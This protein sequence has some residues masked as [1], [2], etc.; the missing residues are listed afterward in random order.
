MKRTDAA[1]MTVAKDELAGRIEPF[2]FDL[3]TLEEYEI[4]RVPAASLLTWNRLDLALK[5]LYLD[6]KDKNPELAREIYQQ[7]IRSQTL[8]TFVEHGNTSK[9][10]FDKYVSAFNE[11]AQSVR[12]EGFDNSK[13][14]VPLSGT[15]AIFNGAHRVA[16]AIHAG[17]EVT[18]ALTELPI[19]VCDYRFY[20]RSGVPQK[21]IEM[22]VQKYV[23]HAPGVFIAFLW[24][25]GIG[26]L[27]LSVEKF[28]NIVY[29]KTIR[30][31]L[32]GGRNLLLELYKH[33]DWIGSRKNGYSGINQKLIEC[34]PNESEVTTVVFQAHTLDEVREIKD[35]IRQIHG[36]GFSS[37]HITDTREE[38][39]RVSRLL[40]NEHGL[41]F[42]NYAIPDKFHPDREIQEFKQFIETGGNKAADV[43][44]DGSFLL[45][46][47]GIRESLDVDFLSQLNIDCG[48]S[49]YDSHDDQLKYH[50]VK[51]AD[52]L[53]DP[54]YHFIFSGLKFVSFGQLRRM[55]TRRSEAKDR[56]D[57]A[58][59]SRLQEP[60]SLGRLI[61]SLAQRVFFLQL[62]AKTLLRNSCVLLLKKIGLYAPV[63][64]FYWRLMR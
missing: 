40:F 3:L 18:C 54:D 41:H 42:L 6:L 63:R 52:L 26:K 43:V 39:V 53:Y 8:G 10:S 32:N 55:K 9:N 2:I 61:Q 51:K 16:S 20:Q 4:A 24:P 38:A 13:S 64:R 58:L 33:M 14:L 7:D 17:C 56:H 45:T 44:I 11:I 22:A 37:V 5:M 31:S 23:E 30:L 15:G 62:R 46:L 1:F 28:P 48:G 59:M 34:F 50:S 35:R 12:I 19:H 29:K 21:I 60:A 36:I 27:A 25:S 49:S 47:Y 57:L